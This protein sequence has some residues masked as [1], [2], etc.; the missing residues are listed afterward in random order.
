[1]NDKMVKAGET[2]NRRQKAEAAAF[3]A[4]DEKTAAQKALADEINEQKNR[5]REINKS[6]ETKL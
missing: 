4:I 6:Y 5:E 3:L 1:M 2:K